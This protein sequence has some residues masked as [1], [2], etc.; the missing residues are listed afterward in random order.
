MRGHHHWRLVR[1]Y[2]GEELLGVVSKRGDCIGIQHHGGFRGEY[3]AHKLFGALT[4]PYAGTNQDSILALIGEQTCQR[5]RIISLAHHDGRELRRI[6]LDRVTR[7]RDG[8]EAGA[9]PQ[10]TTRTKSCR[11]GAVGRSRYDNHMATR[12]FVTFRLGP[13]EFG[14]PE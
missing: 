11:P 4:Y 14:K 13:G 5:P 12:I 1:L 9:D 2:R 3:R 8:D 7:R 6:D 10:C